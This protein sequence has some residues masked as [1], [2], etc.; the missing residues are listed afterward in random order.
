MGSAGGGGGGAR[1]DEAPR[2]SNAAEDHNILEPMSQ[3]IVVNGVPYDSLEAMPPDVRAQYERALAALREIEPSREKHV[4]SVPGG[5]KIDVTTR[6]VQYNIDGK[7]YDDPAQLPPE[8]RAKVERALAGSH[9]DVHQQEP[10]DVRFVNVQMDR[11]K[12]GGG[13]VL[14]WLVI[15]ALVI[16]AIAVLR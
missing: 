14:L 3:R 7:T 16:V 5:V 8:I 13:T 1:A 6:R 4:Q 12:G 11:P 15:A 9:I 2:V 10:T